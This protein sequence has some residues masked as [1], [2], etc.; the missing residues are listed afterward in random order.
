MTKAP[1]SEEDPDWRIA[2]WANRLMPLAELFFK[3][4]TGIGALV[5][6]A[7]ALLSA[8]GHS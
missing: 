1:D 6:V 8:L 5:G 2:R 3:I 7:L 4:A